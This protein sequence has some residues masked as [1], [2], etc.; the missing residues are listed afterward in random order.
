MLACSDVEFSES[1]RSV[2]AIDVHTIDT[3]LE[4]INIKVD[5][6]AFNS[7]YANPG[8]GQE[9]PV[10][11]D[12]FDNDHDLIESDIMANIK[13]R[14][15]GSAFYA[16]KSFEVILDQSY[17]QQDFEFVRDEPKLSTHSLSELSNF[18]LRNSGQDFFNTFLKDKAYNKLAVELGLDFES[19]YGTKTF[20]V[21]INNSYHGL[22]NARSE[23]NITG[24]SNLIG[25]DEDQMVMYKV[26][27]FNQ[28]LEF[29]QGN[30][31]LIADLELAIDD[32]SPSELYELIDISSFIDYI[33]YEDYIGNFDWPN[34]NIRMYSQNGEPFRCVL[35]DLD[36]AAFQTKEV[37][38]PRMEY[39][40]YDLAKL[41]QKL[42][43]VTGFDELLRVRRQEIYDQVSPELFNSIVDEFAAQ[44][45][46]EIHY[47][48]DKYETPESYFHWLAS[49]EKLKIDFEARDSFIRNYYN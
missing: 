19:M 21:F 8:S 38:L 10:E 33:I 27:R 16:L 35:Y 18:R 43:Q 40:D 20:Q 5:S 17:I 23:S 39:Q 29:H 15:V 37:Y 46:Q 42:R 41:Y 49:L 14:G 44:I 36:L 12:V 26:N 7:F 34:N 2:D 28:N 25:V 32:F 24:V 1:D 30:E 3:D 6:D 9:L 47:L 31:N 22:L 13:I 11:L 45:E 4:I 48:I